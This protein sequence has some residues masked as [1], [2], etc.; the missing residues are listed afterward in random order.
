[1]EMGTPFRLVLS[2]EDDFPVAGVRG[3]TSRHLLPLVP[4]LVSAFP[5]LRH[6]PSICCPTP[7]QQD[8][9]DCTRPAKC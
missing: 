1:M 9:Y 2:L 8:Q 4:L 5:L 3:E 6:R 7:L